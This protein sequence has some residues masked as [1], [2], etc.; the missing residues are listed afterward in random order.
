MRT[1]DAIARDGAAAGEE[2][3]GARPRT[4]NRPSQERFH[5]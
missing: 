3:I 1:L 4:A 2:S 5:V